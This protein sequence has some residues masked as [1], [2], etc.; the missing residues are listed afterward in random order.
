MDDSCVRTGQPIRGVLLLW[1]GWGI[2]V[3]TPR[4]KMSPFIHSAVCLVTGQSLFQGESSTESV[5]VL[6]LSISNILSFPQGYIVGA[7][8]FDTKILKTTLDLLQTV[9][10]TVMNLLFTQNLGSP[11]LAEQTSDSQA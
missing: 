10:I 4:R 5:L 3:A 9:V 6:P 1:F 7:Y 2:Q 8:V 11:L